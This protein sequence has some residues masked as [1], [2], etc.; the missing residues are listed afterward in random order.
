M[1]VSITFRISI[2]IFLEVEW[3][4]IAICDSGAFRDLGDTDDNGHDGEFEVWVREGGDNQELILDYCSIEYIGII[5]LL[6][7]IANDQDGS[8]KI[9]YE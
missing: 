9:A 4:F 6:N 8:I 1:V 3:P 2:K 7:I 5:E